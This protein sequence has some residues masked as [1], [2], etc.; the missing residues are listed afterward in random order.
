MSKSKTK[1]K[2]GA[3]IGDRG[4]SWRVDVVWQ[5][6][7]V[8]AKDEDVHAMRIELLAKVLAELAKECGCGI[9][10]AIQLVAERA[11]ELACQRG[12]E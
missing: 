3:S 2:L 8:D 5:A 6:S 12:D 1:V 11:I 7:P 4:K 9:E 10:A